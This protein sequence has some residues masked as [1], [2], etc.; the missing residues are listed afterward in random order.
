MNNPS[1]SENEETKRFRIDKNSPINPVAFDLNRDPMYQQLLVFYQEGQ[2]HKCKLAIDKLFK[3]YPGHP[4]LFKFR[5]E[6]AMKLSVKDLHSKIREE[7]K[8][9]KRMSTLSLSLMVMIGIIVILVTL[10]LSLMFFSDSL[11]S[12]EP[13]EPNTIPMEV[14][15]DM[16]YNQADGLLQSGETGQVNR[17]IEIITEI[18]PEYQNLTELQARLGTIQN[19]EIQ[20]QA[21]INLVDEDRFIDALEIFQGIEAEQPGLWDVNRQIAAIE[22]SALIEKQLTDGHTAYQDENWALAITAYESLLQVTDN[23]FDKSIINQRLLNSYLNQVR[24]ILTQDTL[25][26]EEIETAEDHY[27]KAESLI[28]ENPALAGARDQL[29]ELF[30]ILQNVKENNTQ[31]PDTVAPTQVGNAWF[32]QGLLPN[33]N[34]PIGFNPISNQNWVD[35]ATNLDNT[36]NLSLTSHPNCFIQGY[37]IL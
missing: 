19:L 21:A 24:Q 4:G 27:Q 16:L 3:K 10:F 12:P 28:A 2:F 23:N 33:Q 25:T 30:N 22:D 36:Q 32:Q 20:Y 26:I 29:N 13:A 17:I 35:A 5:D 31:T 6:L 18:E 1:H 11:T 15:L 34:Y 8:T 9:I 7:E 14:Q 37:K